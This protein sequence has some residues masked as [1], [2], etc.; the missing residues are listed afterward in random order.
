MENNLIE[1]YELIN[2]TAIIDKEYNIVTANEE[3]YRFLGLN[4][5]TSILE[6][7][8][9]V[10]AD[11]FIDVCTSLPPDQKKNMVLRMRRNDN[12][13]RWMLVNVTRCNYVAD[14]DSVEYWELEISDI[15]S[16]KSKNESLQNSVLGFRHLMA[17]ENEL[18]FIYDF[19]TKIFRISNF[20]DNEISNLIE[21]PIDQV[22]EILILKNYVSPESKEQLHLFCESVRS[23]K[24]SFTYQIKAN[25]TTQNQV[26]H[27]FELK[28][29]SIYSNMVPRKVVGSIKNNAESEDNYNIKTYEFSNDKTLMS[30]HEVRD[31]SEK[32][33]KYN[34]VCNLSLFL[35]QIDHLDEI[36][37]KC[38]KKFVE[39]LFETVIHTSRKMLGYRGIIC[40]IQYNLYSIAMKDL[41][42]EDYIR[43]FIQSLRSN[44][45]WLY[46]K[47]NAPVDISFSVG[48]A[49]YPFNGTDLSLIHRKLVRA[50]EIAQ[51]RGGNRYIIYKEYLHG[52]VD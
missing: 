11:D 48:I 43:A 21:L 25:F 47:Q 22:E 3:T 20:I 1:K 31:F 33:I 37:Q 6:V 29:S 46:Q 44:I 45:Q 4:L 26:Y 30:Y 35:M 8:H 49:R 13:F 40:E 39:E 14:S 17:M 2:G 36:E 52:E 15:I 5:N 12:S 32:N 34:P 24:V 10:D 50:L 27:D 38:G 16:L 7:I 41:N 51:E 28:G 18:F 23:G 9:Q 19:D 42:N